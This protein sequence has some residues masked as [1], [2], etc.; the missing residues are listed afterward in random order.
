MTT[1]MDHPA[2]SR[3]GGLLSRLHA[4]MSGL[5]PEP[6]LAVLMRLGIAAPFLLSGRTK[7]EGVLTVTDTTFYLFAEE[8]RVPL[9]PSE[10][11]A[12]AATYAEHLFPVLIII[13]LGTRVSAVA[14]LVMTLVIQLFVVPTGWPTHLLWLAPLVYLIGRGPGPFSLDRLLKID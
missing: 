2:E 7:V 6:A 1:L 10:L 5:V 13:G 3:S 4:A 9:L 14:L 12:Y 8:Y 11:A